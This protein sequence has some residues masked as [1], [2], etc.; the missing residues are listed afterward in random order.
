MPFFRLRQKIELRVIE[1]ETEEILDRAR[2]GRYSRNELIYLPG[3]ADTI[4]TI[5]FSGSPAEIFLKVLESV[6]EG[7]FQRNKDR[8]K[9]GCADFRNLK[10]G[11]FRQAG[12]RAQP[13]MIVSRTS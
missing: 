9:G 2:R 1:P 12:T 4:E 8:H 10:P 13:N 3:E 7:G 11:E 6:E 5:E